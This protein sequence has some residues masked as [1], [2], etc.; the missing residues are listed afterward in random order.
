MYRELDHKWLKCIMILS[1]VLLLTALGCVSR[2]DY[3][4]LQ[5]KH[6]QVIN[7]QSTI[8]SNLKTLRS[9][10]ELL[11]SRNL[12]LEEQNGRLR[13]TSQVLLQK[14]QT[15][16]EEVIDSRSQALESRKELRKK[17]EALK[18]TSATY[19]SLITSLEDEVKDGRI[20][21]Q[22][23]KEGVS[24][25][26]SNKIVFQTGSATINKAGRNVLRRVASILKKSEH[27]R[28]MVEGHSDSLPTTGT[29]AKRYPTNWE[30]SSARAIAVVKLLEEH[31][32]QSKKLIPAGRSSYQPIASNKTREGRSQ[33]RRIEIELLP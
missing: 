22:E 7:D 27:Q 25:T 32:V 14:N 3:D 1:A 20:S 6:Q 4:S 5:R 23:M 33:N 17:E 31:G 24:L 29:L 16:N 13:N 10:N 19:R 26:L 2:G 9:E 28:I 8:R 15:L 11:K 12:E 30:L 18:E 21:I